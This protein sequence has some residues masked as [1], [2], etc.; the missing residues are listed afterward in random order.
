[1]QKIEKIIQKI[2]FLTAIM[3]SG[4]IGVSYTNNVYASQETE[5][6]EEAENSDDST[7]QDEE[8]ETQS[9]DDD[10]IYNFKDAKKEGTITL[11]KK[12]KDRKD[13]DSRPVPDIEISTA[14]PRQ[15]ASGYT[16]TFNGNGM[17]FSDGTQIN[18][19]VF[20]SSMEIVSGQYKIPTGVPYVYWYTEPACTNRVKVS[21]D[22]I[23]E[24]T[25]SADVTLYAK[26]VTFVL[27]TGY[28]FSQLI[29]DEVT[30]II[31]TDEEMPADAEL[32][33]VDEDG[34]EGVVAWVENGVMKVS[35]QIEEIEI[36]FNASSSSMFTTKKNLVNITFD[37]ID[38]S[39]V[40]A[41]GYMFVE[42]SSLTS[43]DLS[44]F[45]TSKV[46]GM[47]GMFWNCSNLKTVISNFDTSNLIWVTSFAN[48]CSSL[49]EFNVSNWNT[50]KVTS[51]NDMFN[52]C[53]S[54]ESLDVSNW[55]TSKMDGMGYTF[56]NCSSLTQLDV[57][58]WDTSKV[59]S[60]AGMFSGCSKLA[61]LNVS[62]F[63]TQK[64]TNMSEFFWNCR[65]LTELDVS[66]FNT[67]NVTAMSNMFGYCTN[68]PVFDV[69]RFNTAKV[70]SM[71]CMFTCCS[72]VTEFN[73]SSFDTSNVV[74]M[75]Q[76]FFGCSGIKILDLSSFYTPNV[77][78]VCNMF[79][80]CTNLAS[81]DISN[82]DTSKVTNMNWTFSNLNSLKTLS[83]GKDF[84][85]VGTAHGLR[86]MWMNSEDEEF[87]AME[88]PNNVKETYTRIS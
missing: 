65:G 36:R 80:L 72:K 49:Q 15:N 73:V 19:M 31:F 46:T 17:A 29:P 56:F 57:S 8:V 87:D 78:N 83:L 52:G 12:W 58:S 55:D 27:K 37:N 2:V 40:T 75:E 39:N 47:T 10:L 60:F 48:G 13:N 51:I 62:G 25:L 81:L 67:E 79:N 41:M 18:K 44:N 5:S 42:C 16:V 76:M 61:V 77:T 21:K 53:K 20:N 1:M 34:D 45:N 74:N 69:S 82:I 54:L 43:L 50:S 71:G 22:G 11:T 63:N 14:K 70:K 84:A 26:A 9:S 6:F 32:I 66:N 3:V 88:I 23:P 28:T 38:T 30:S 4:V 85:F 64:A 7:L 68:V 33:D 35:T 86:G 24:M 59:T